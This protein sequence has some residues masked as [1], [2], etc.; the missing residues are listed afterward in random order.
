MTDNVEYLLNERQMLLLCMRGDAKEAAR[1]DDTRAEMVEVI[2]AWR[3]GELLP[4]HKTPLLNAL[5]AK[6]KPGP[7]DDAA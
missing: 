1:A 7:G 5:Y 2:R 6:A 4:K 3:R